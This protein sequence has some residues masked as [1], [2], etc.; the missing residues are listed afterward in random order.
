M[1]QFNQLQVAFLHNNSLNLELKER[2]SFLVVQ[3]QRTS[4]L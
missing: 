1:F 3:R 4:Y 2:Y